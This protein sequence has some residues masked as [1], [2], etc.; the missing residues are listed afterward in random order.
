MCGR[1]F[2]DVTV[3][4]LAALAG[5]FARAD[6]L[7]PRYNIAPEQP[8]P[9]IREDALGE[10]RLALVRWGLVPSWSKGP[11]P[12]FSMINARAETVAEKPAYRAALRYRRCLIPASGFYEW[13]PT[14]RGLKQPFVIRRQ[15][16][17]PFMFAGL[18]EHWLGAD[19]SELDS[20]S[21]IV[22]AANAAVAPVHERM[23]VILEPANYGIWLDRGHQHTDD[24]LP[25]LRPSPAEDLEVYRV[26]RE[27]NNPQKEGPRLIQPEAG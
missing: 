14:G 16:H 25:L 4:E 2:L 24:L 22:T 15:D 1:F 3:E 12:K 18:W 6:A 11:D 7:A 5:P 23:P 19:G 26:D 21:I 27:V 20:C 13:R 10:R 17:R 9:I 8:V